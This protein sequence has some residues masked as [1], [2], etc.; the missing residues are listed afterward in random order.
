MRKLTICGRDIADYTIVIPSAPHP[1]EQTAADFLKRVVETACGVTLP[2]ASDAGE[3]GIYIGTRDASPEVKWDGFRV[4][5]DERNVYLDGNIPRGTVYAVFDFAEKHLGYR[6]F[7]NDCEII[8]AEGEGTVPA[9]LDVVDNPTFV[10]RR[11]D[12][13]EVENHPEFA[14]HCRIN[15]APIHLNKVIGEELGGMANAPFDAHSFGRLL[16]GAV[17]FDEHPEY[18]ALVDGERIP[19]NN[20]AG[21]GQLCLTNPDVVRLVT[22]AVLNQLRENPTLLEVE[23]SH[24]DNGNY[25]RCEHCAA[26]DEEEG[27]QAGTMIRFVNAVAEAVEKEFPDVLIST[28]AYEHT[29]VPPKKTKARHNVIVRYCTYD[30]CFRHPIDSP[31]CPINRTSTYAEMMGWQEKCEHMS[32]WDYVTNWDCFLAP[33]PNLRSLRENMRFYH[34]CHVRQVFAEDD[35]RTRQGGVF[36]DLKAYLIGKLMWN[37]YMSDEEYEGHINEFLAGFYGNAW[38][39]MRRY[40]DLEYE[41]TADRCFTCKESIDIC[42]LHVVTNPPIPNYKMLMRRNY[43]PQPYQPML[44][45]HALTGLVERMDEVEACFDRAMALAEDDG[46]KERIERSRM[47][48]TYVD[49]FCSGKNEFTM[50]A[51][52]KA[53]YMARVEQFY[54]DKERFRLLY[55]NHT[56]FNRGR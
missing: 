14:A 56:A 29:R 52:E 16:P 3:C 17:Y 28:F 31:S 13:Y 10:V 24:C 19:C 47:G 21:P 22:E 44:P 36:F 9:G 43:L 34:K 46:V 8:P 40:L 32:I 42:F 2:M 33:F 6:R 15:T 55:N 27:S 1:A 20:G 48:V 7:A 37:P 41:V 5:T 23:V 30:A 51:E 11:Y 18:Y 26:I 25:C 35:P 49:L 39:E 38:R 54:K 12:F 53:L 4:T 45:N 50:S